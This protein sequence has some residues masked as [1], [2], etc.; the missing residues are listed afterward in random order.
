MASLSPAP[1]RPVL[2]VTDFADPQLN[3]QILALLGGLASAGV[4]VTLA[5]PLTRRWQNRLQSLGVRWTVLPLAP[6]LEPAGRRT[7][8][9]QLQRL[10][11][12]RPWQ[13][14][15]THELPALR[16][17]TGA[18]RRL[19]RASRPPLVASLYALPRRLSWEERWSWRWQTRGLFRAGAAVIVPSEVDRQTLRRQ[20]GPAAPRVHV[21]YPT[22]MQTGRPSG[23]ESGVLRGLLKLSGHAA[24]VGLATTL[25]EDDTPVF[26]Q[27]AELVQ[28]DLPNLEFAVLGE[29]PRLE[30]A[31]QYAHDRGLS[32]ATVFLGRSRSVS[33]VISV[34]NVLVVLSD[35]GGAHL[36]A[37]QAVAYGIPVVAARVGVLAEMLNRLPGVRLV[38]PDDPRELATAIHDALQAL[39]E[40]QDPL[41][42]R[43]SAPGLAA[44]HPWLVSRDYWDLE[45]PWDRGALRL[46]SASGHRPELAAF[47][48]EHAVARVVALYEDLA[49]A[50]PPP[51]SH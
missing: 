9:E 41:T 37:L 45:A 23:V 18:L 48:P 7:V 50:D 39:P 11:T 3:E 19:A 13:I 32:G 10:L 35:A 34:L 6:E 15:H 22:L 29:G 40:W 1:G 43:E 2:H 21:L 20:G 46:P 16:V 51:S 42:A 8:T 27:A 12:S 33:E 14:V 5:A 26:L 49:G 38:S 36:Q 25:E 4:E 31:R 44:G 24:V 17:A 28:Q 47:T 30:A